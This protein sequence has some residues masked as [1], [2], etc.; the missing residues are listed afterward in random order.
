LKE[1]SILRQFLSYVLLF[2]S[3]LFF[4][5]WFSDSLGFGLLLVTYLSIQKNVLHNVETVAAYPP[6]PT[7]GL[8]RSL[9]VQTSFAHWHVSPYL[10]LVISADSQYLNSRLVTHRDLWR[11]KF[12]T[13]VGIHAICIFTLHALQ[14]FLRTRLF[15][16]RQRR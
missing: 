12:I 1:I 2:K 7:I 4:L 5:V 14:F 10:K 9:T 16:V 13:D 11:Y 3:L 15:V 6:L 8:F